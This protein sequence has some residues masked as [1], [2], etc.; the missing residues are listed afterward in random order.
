MISRWNQASRDSAIALHYSRERA[1]VRSKRAADPLSFLEVGIFRSR[2]SG[3]I[4]GWKSGGSTSDRNRDGT[5]LVAECLATIRMCWV[6]SI[7]CAFI[8]AGSEAVAETTA[9]SDSSA[10][11]TRDNGALTEVVVTARRRSE[12]LQK[13]PLA[14]TAVTAERIQEQDIVSLQDLNSLVPNLKIAN[15]R[16]TSSTIN[17][18]IRGVGQSDPLWGYEPGVGVYIDD[19]YLA[20][21]QAA[22]L[23]IIDAGRIEILRGPQG[24]LYGKNT[25]AGAIRYLTPDIVGPTTLTVSATVGNYGEHDEKINVATPLFTDR[26]YFALTIAELQRDGYGHVVAQA[27]RASSSY[28]YIGEDVSNKD[29]LAGRANLTIVLGQGSKLKIVADDTLDNSNA[30]GG[31]RLN[32]YLAPTL[33]NPFDTQTDMPVNRNFS[34][35]RDVATTYLQKL[36]SRLDLKVVGAYGEGRSQQFNDLDELDENLFQVPSQFNDRQA[37][38]EAQLLFTGDRI[39]AVTGVFYMD[40]R[41]CGAQDASNGGLA[42]VDDIYLTSLIKGCDRTHSAA[43]YTDDVWKLSD[44]LDLDAGLRWSQDSKAAALFQQP[45]CCG[46]INERWR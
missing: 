30:P 8:V 12:D 46:M 11:V 20:R 29:V 14:V 43:L 22:L 6:A 18:Y 32:G 2:S 23:D 19:M 45:I 5:H 24:T 38:T 7:P 15:D 17:V 28:N 34:H 10:A 1:E 9:E 21:P 26:V 42:S 33:D 35:R 36:G 31:Q 16:A 44:R 27:G 25:I 13:V 40:S 41:S 37:S 4:L 39:Q 3:S